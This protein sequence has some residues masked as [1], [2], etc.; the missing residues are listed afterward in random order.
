MQKRMSYSTTLFADAAIRGAN[1][2]REW[3]HRHFFIDL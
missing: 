2:R 1:L 3:R